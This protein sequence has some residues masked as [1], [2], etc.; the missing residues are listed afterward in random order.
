MTT[1]EFKLVPKVIL[2]SRVTRRATAKVRRS[3][4]HRQIQPLDERGVQLVGV[5]GVV[6][7]IP[8]SPLVAYHQLRLDA[9]D[10]VLPPGLDDLTVDVVDPERSLDHECV[11]L[12]TVG[13]DQRKVGPP[14]T[15]CSVEKE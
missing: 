4:P 11:V 12:V 5:F 1:L 3:L 14:S 7:R 8:K 10:P 9:R 15:L 6:E 2:R 13:C